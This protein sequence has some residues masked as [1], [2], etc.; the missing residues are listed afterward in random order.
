MIVKVRALFHETDEAC[1][2]YYNLFTWLHVSD[3]CNFGNTNGSFFIDSL[4]SNNRLSTLAL[5][6]LGRI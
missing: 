6:E 1:H 3:Y 4:P 2:V 5:T